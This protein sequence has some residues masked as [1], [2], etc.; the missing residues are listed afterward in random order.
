M[1]KRSSKAEWPAKFDVRELDDDADSYPPLIH[2]IPTEL[3]SG[4]QARQLEPDLSP[5]IAAALLS[6]ETGI[7]DSHTYMESL[8]RDIMDTENGQ[9]VYSTAV[10]RVDPYSRSAQAQGSA[11]IDAHE[12]GWVVQMTTRGTEGEGASDALLAR[13]LIN[14]SGLSA[15]LVLNSLLPYDQR[16]PMYYARGSY[17]AYKGPGV[18]DVSRL[19]YPCPDTDKSGHAFQ[20]LGTH[21]T[22]DLERN[23]RFGPDLQWI[24]PTHV[25]TQPTAKPTPARPEG[26]D[27]RMEEFSF[28]EEDVDFWKQHLVP[29]ETQLKA[30]FQAVR[31]YLPGVDET[32]FHPDYVGIRPKLVPPWGGFQDFVFRADYSGSFSG[33]GA[34]NSIDKAG[35]GGRMISLMGIESPGLTASLAIAEKTAEMLKVK[36]EVNYSEGSAGKSLGSVD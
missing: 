19:I 34:N 30:M 27:D 15:Q 6:H 25:S 9:V 33:S 5:S 4:D 22:L 12:D 3:I 18:R 11:D 2:A 26:N 17:C 29:D 23:V 16:I 28:D 1:H 32:R 31:R 21:L 35:E 20:S 10:V 7:I 13:T 24:S 8:E 14:A 36:D